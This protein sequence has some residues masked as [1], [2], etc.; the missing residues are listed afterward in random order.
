MTVRPGNVTVHVGALLEPPSVAP[1]A[2]AIDKLADYPFDRWD[3]RKP[4]GDIAQDEDSFDAD[5]KRA[6]ELSLQDAKGESSSAVPPPLPPRPR[7]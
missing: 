6:I 7:K 3:Q 2:A 5:L 4:M 1:V